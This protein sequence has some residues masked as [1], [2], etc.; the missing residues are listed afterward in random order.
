MGASEGITAKQEQISPETT[1]AWT[2][3]SKWPVND[4]SNGSAEG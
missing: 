1:S 2:Q 3:F 4:A